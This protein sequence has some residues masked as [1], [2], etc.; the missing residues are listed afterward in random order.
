MDAITLQQCVTPCRDALSKLKAAIGDESAPSA[1]LGTRLGSQAAGSDAADVVPAETE[2]S[3]PYSLPAGQS[4]SSCPYY[5]P[6]K[7][8]SNKP[9]PN[10]ILCFCREWKCC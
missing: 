1:N 8:T 7:Q 4:S 10:L 5:L 6:E 3:L 2:T 9:V